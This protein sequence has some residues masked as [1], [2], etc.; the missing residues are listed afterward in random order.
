MRARER[1]RPIRGL[2]GALSFLTRL[3]L[4]RRA[5]TVTE[6]DLRA[7]VGWFPAVGAI[8]G[9]AGATGGWL[10]GMRAPSAVAGVVVV[11]LDTAATGAFH[12]DGLA[13]TADGIG[14]AST[15]RD[16]LRVMRESTVGAFG[17]VAL[18]LDLALRIAATAS[19]LSAGAFP[20]AI[21]SAAAAARFAP[22]MLAGALP[23]V[24]P[25]GGTGSWVGDGVSRSALALGGVTAVAIAAA[26]G[27]G[28]GVAIIGT[29]LATTVIVG[30][31]ARSWFGGATG[32]V[33][34]ASAELAQTVAL[35]AVVVMAGR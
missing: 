15:G 4:G 35:T 26:A 28:A 12:L 5:A 21:V 31:E 1:S 11:V 13:D 25:E 18:V 6:A 17:V 29:V 8:V 20:W 7:G 22:L 16:G 14:A 2:V 3:P 24:R 27:A 9:L 32:D 23:Y 34:G 10:V 19:L 33:F 30:A